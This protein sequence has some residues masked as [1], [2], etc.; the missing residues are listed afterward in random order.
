MVQQLLLG[1]G[2]PGIQQ[3]HVQSKESLGEKARA[4]SCAATEEDAKQL[5][6][7]YSCIRDQG[8]P[9]PSF[10]NIGVRE[11]KPPLLHSMCYQLR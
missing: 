6:P 7:L 10:S 2:K 1:L 11:D 4:L 9:I 8:R 3:P 5:S